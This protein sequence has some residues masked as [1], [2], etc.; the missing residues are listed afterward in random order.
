MDKKKQS[1]FSR[2]KK[3][4]RSFF[5]KGVCPYQFSFGLLNPFRRFILSPSELVNRLNLMSDSR[6]LELGP[7]PG[8][9]SREI[10]NRVDNGQH[11]MA[12]IQKE[13]LEK[14]RSR[15][16]SN[17]RTGFIQANGEKMPFLDKTFDVVFLVA[18]LGE[19]PDKLMC[20][21]E[22]NRILTDNG[23][24]SITEQPGDPD[25]LT[26]KE[27]LEIAELAGFRQRRIYGKGSNF[28]LNL[29]R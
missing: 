23:L 24:L 16:G 17:N 13:M 26:T 14:V 4:V 10:S 15:L 12:D 29:I 22:I 28:T 9:F 20:L 27:I 5:G 2:M 25:S 11:I 19:I 21:K 3:I 7:G 18:V 8:Y 1:R 6:I